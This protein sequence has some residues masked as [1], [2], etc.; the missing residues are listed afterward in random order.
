VVSFARNEVV[1]SGIAGGASPYAHRQIVLEIASVHGA[2]HAPLMEVAHIR[3]SPGSFLGAGEGRQQQRR[4]NCDNRND[5]EQLN[6]SEPA[7]HSHFDQSHG[8]ASHSR[9][10][11]GRQSKSATPQR[12]SLNQQKQPQKKGK[13][14]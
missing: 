10:A 14:T 4:Q 5:H 1:G 12:Q 2:G 13:N 11:N 6:Q 9:E 7:A 3:R 8:D